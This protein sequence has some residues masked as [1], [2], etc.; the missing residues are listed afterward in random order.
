MIKEKNLNINKDNIRYKFI[1]TAGM[2]EQDNGNL[3]IYGWASTAAPDSMDEI[4]PVS[5]MEKTIESYW[6]FANIREMHN[7]FL[8]GA[9]KCTFA[10]VD[11]NGLWIEAEIVDESVKKK[12]RE[13]VYK[14]L[15]IGYIINSKHREGKFLILDDIELIEISVVDRGMNVECLIEN[16]QKII[17]SVHKFIEMNKKRLLVA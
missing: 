9:G 7:P 15:S 14:G 5:A 10:Q 6:K 16:E 3:L 8:G 2:Q 12:C 1:K 17:E 4:V 11:E 13:K